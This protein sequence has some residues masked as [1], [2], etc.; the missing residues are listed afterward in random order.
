MDGQK[1]RRQKYRQKVSQLS[2]CPLLS[3]IFTLF[4]PSLHVFPCIQIPNNYRGSG[5]VKKKIGGFRGAQSKSRKRKGGDTS[6][7][8]D[9]LSLSD[10]SEGEDSM[11]DLPSDEELPDQDDT[12]E[13]VQHCLPQ[14]CI[15]HC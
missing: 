14:F 10:G 6:S 12:D 1:H 5:Y 15:Y 11:E 9:E 7:E 8:D 3:L 13:E 4:F 2:P